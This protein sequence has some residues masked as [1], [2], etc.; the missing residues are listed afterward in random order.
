MSSIPTGENLP[1]A[2]QIWNK[3]VDRF[4][5]ARAFTDGGSELTG[6]PANVPHED[7][8]LYLNDMAIA[9][10]NERTVHVV[11]EVFRDAAFLN[12][13]TEYQTGT[14]S[15]SLNDVASAVDDLIAAA[16]RG[17]FMAVL[18]KSEKVATIRETERVAALLISEERV[19]VATLEGTE[20]ISLDSKE[21]S[22]V[23][24]RPMKN[25]NYK[26]APTWL[27]TTDADPQFQAFN[28]KAKTLNGFTLNWNS[29]V[30]SA[31]YVVEWQVH[32]V[33]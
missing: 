28:I 24:Q 33:Q 20:S 19:Q 31:N 30:V 12:K 8:G 21:V 29:G 4:V 9:M 15:F 23:L 6:S 7:D 18:K 10:P 14:E 22:V 3:R 27:N 16:R 13:D 5:R 11:Y 25:L 17:E 32:E 26:I 1:L 2:A